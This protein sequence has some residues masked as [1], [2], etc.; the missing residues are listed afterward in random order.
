MSTTIKGNASGCSFGKSRIYTAL[1]VETHQNQP[2]LYDAKEIH[3]IL[4]ETPIVTEVQIAHWQ[5]IA[6][7]YMC[8]IGDVYRG[9]MP[10]AL[11]LESEIISQKTDVFV[12]ESTLSDDEFL[13][14]QALQQQSSLKVQDIIAILNKK[15][16]FPVIQN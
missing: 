10:S 6:S 9:A 8:A 13:I 16:I 15:N 1:V 11:L 3:Q 14:F 5:W 12:D 2:T 4:D 7:Y